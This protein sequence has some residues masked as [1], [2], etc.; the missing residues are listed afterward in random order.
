VES[1]IPSRDD[2][3]K[4]RTGEDREAFAIL[5]SIDNQE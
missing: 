2:G 1:V 5:L 4:I 3:V